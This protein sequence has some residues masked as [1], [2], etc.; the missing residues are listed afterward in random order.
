MTLSPLTNRSNQRARRLRLEKATARN[1]GVRRVMVS[2]PKQTSEIVRRKVRA[3]AL[4]AWPTDQ[5]MRQS[6]RRPHC[7]DVALS[8]CAKYILGG[9]QW[10]LSNVHSEFRR[11][12]GRG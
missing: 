3:V 10:T 2:A 9:K 6:R 1:F 7:E 5:S 4:S 8:I 11:T 12:A